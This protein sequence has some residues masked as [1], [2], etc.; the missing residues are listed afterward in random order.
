MDPAS[1]G[2]EDEPRADARCGRCPILRVATYNVHS[3]IGRDRRHDPARIARV[4]GELDADVIA[5]QEF[6]Y[7]AD[8]AL[9][10]RTPVVLTELD[11]YQYALGPTLAR[12]AR[13]YGNLILSKHPIRALRRIDLSHAKREP[14]GLLS[15]S[16]EAHGCELNVLATHLGLG[17]GERRYQIR[18]ILEHVEE[19]SSSFFVLLG[20]FNDW[21]PGRSVA[22]ALDLRLGNTP[23]LRTFPASMPMLPLDRIWV[24]PRGTLRRLWVCRSAAICMASDHLP[25]VAEVEP[26]RS[27]R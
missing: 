9:E 8:V 6:S 24:H 21:L 12:E 13:R 26:P 7:P 19:L 14:R 4:I 18:R 5:L 23:R 3:C 20:D 1:T 16:I 25:V 27:A 2:R 10:T 11:S 17:F 22:R 15:V